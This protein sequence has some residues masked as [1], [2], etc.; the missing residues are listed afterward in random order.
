MSQ[1]L[2]FVAVV[3]LLALPQHGGSMT[4]VETN[5][6]RQIDRAEQI[7][8]ARVVAVTSG[9]SGEGANRH[10]ATFVTFSVQESFRGG[11]AGEQTLEFFGGR[12][13]G[14]TQRIPGM[15]EF[16]PGDVEFL[17]VRGNHRDLCPLVGVHHGRMRVV[18][19]AAD[20]RAQVF[21][22]DGTPLTGLKQVGS[23]GEQAKPAQA[24]AGALTAEE[25]GAKIRDAL[26][27]RGIQAD[28]P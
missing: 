19:N 9:W 18:K 22:H 13:A 7:F 11:A 16:Q 4:V 3:C 6:D 2:R 12:V 21:L 10:V 20:G 28:Q 15:P 8:R 5:F 17:F 14:R 24:A 26:K 25:F 27:R 23:S 1:F